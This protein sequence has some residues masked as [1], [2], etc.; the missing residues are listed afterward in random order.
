MSNPLT[1]AHLRPLSKKPN[2]E[3]IDGA[4][5]LVKKW[6]ERDKKKAGRLENKDKNDRA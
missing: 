4:E 1:I 5:A 3:I 2:Q 6:R